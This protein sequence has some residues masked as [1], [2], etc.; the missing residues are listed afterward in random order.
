MQAISDLR[1]AVD[2]ITGKYA[3]LNGNEEVSRALRPLARAELPPALR[4]KHSLGLG[5][6]VLTKVE[7]GDAGRKPGKGDSPKKKR[8][9]R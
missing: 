5:H 6:R 2:E 7:P 1:T 3:E 9:G 4:H 8:S